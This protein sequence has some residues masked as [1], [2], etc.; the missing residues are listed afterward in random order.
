MRHGGLDDDL[1]VPLDEV[2][3]GALAPGAGDAHAL[4]AV[5]V[6]HELGHDDDARDLNL[7]AGIYPRETLCLRSGFA[8]RPLT[9]VKGGYGAPRDG[10]PVVADTGV[11]WLNRGRSTGRLLFQGAALGVSQPCRHPGPFEEGKDASHVDE[12]ESDL[13]AF[14]HQLQCLRLSSMTIF[15]CKFGRVIKFLNDNCQFNTTNHRANRPAS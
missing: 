8:G 11:E 5:R 10:P 12:I 7:S 9:G 1:D 2:V 3:D 4:L 14:Y 13:Y 6:V 15:L